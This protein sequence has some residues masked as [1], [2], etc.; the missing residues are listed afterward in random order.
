M[1]SVTPAALAF[2]A[3]LVAGALPSTAASASTRVEKTF[4]K[5]AV[6]CVDDDAGNRNCSMNQS[7]PAAAPAHGAALIVVIRG[8]KTQQTL[9]LIVP[10]GVSLKDGVSLTLGDPPTALSYSQCTP[11]ACVATMPID[12]KILGAFKGTQKVM[13]NYVLGNKKL[14]QAAIDPTS[15]GDGYNYLT[16]QLQ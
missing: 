3:V 12:S 15:F 8:T 11:R 13:A 7:I 4:G 9:T 6:T 5:W 14:I 10:T 2:V 16:S 1:R